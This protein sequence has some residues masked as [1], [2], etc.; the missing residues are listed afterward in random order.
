MFFSS[1]T[2]DIS[3]E[4]AGVRA[5]VITILLIAKNEYNAHTSKKE[6]SQVKRFTSTLAVPIVLS[7]SFDLMPIKKSWDLSLYLP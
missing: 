2:E 4:G 1:R 7:I 6:E 5:K 3:D